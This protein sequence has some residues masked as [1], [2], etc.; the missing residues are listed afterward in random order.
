MA[1]PKRP[2]DINERAKFIVDILTGEKEE[3]NPNEGKNMAAVEL[4]KL[5][6]KARAENL[7]EEERIEIAKK[8]A[9]KRWKK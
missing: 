9:K 5:G 4:G 2:T 3:I 7:T 1:K 8:A 6:G